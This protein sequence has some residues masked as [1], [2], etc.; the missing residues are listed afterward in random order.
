MNTKSIMP[1]K[2]K[3]A[4]LKHKK[5][6][7]E[8]DAV[9]SELSHSLTKTLSSKEKKENGIFFTPPITVHNSLKILQP[10]MKH[11]KT[12]L[13]PSCGSGEFLNGLLKHKQP[14][15][16]TGIELNTTIYN[17]IK[18]QYTNMNIVNEDFLSYTTEQKYDLIIGNPPYFVM[19]KN[20]VEPKYTPY[21][22]GRPN[23]F[24][25]FI[26]KSMEL[27]AEE[28]ILCFVL[29][30][31]FLNCLYYDK[32][33]KHINENY[34]IIDIVNCDGSYIETK[35]ETILMVVQH[36]KS[37]NNHTFILKKETYTLFGTP[38]V[39][40]TLRELYKGS[41]TLHQEGFTVN[42]G[43][44]VWNQC[45]DLLT[46]D[47]SKTLLIYSSDIKNNTLDIQ[48]YHNPEKKNY[49]VKQGSTVPLLVVNRGYGV[50]NYKFEYALI[51]GT[52]EYLIENHLICIRFNGEIERSELIKLYHKIITSL[53][54][55]KTNQFITLYF[56]N[57]AINTTELRYVL[58]LYI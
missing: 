21:F 28:G 16:V 13:E 41:T 55:D 27:L 32:T 33:R 26:M 51:D 38:T 20:S 52:Q 5:I 45:K 39:I 12:V 11:I 6:I 46:N 29:P 15:D 58:P 17:S 7:I 31:S 18:T 35:Q 47:A 36:K 53:E 30:K 2:K 3:V 14:L 54:N 8:E 48:T 57:N 1:T 19:K 44:V 23:I 42:V 40:E 22:D 10:Y 9:Y 25:L 24:I 43:N 56:G 49:I 37:D 50:G 4:S 34:T